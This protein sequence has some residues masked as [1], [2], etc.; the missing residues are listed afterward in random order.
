MDN[1][2]RFTNKYGDEWEFEYCPSTCSG[3][4]RGSDIDWEESLVI[5]GYA[6]GLILNREERAW[7]QLVWIQAIERERFK[8]V[9][10]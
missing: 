8:H 7:L 4:L 1:I 3:V 5:D 10:P 6:P 9:T 2:A